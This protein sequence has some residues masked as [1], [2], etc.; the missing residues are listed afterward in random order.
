MMTTKTK[1][2]EVES[3][4]DRELDIQVPIGAFAEGLEPHDKEHAQRLVDQAKQGAQMFVTALIEL[5]QHRD[6]EPLGFANWQEL[7][8]KGIGIRQVNFSQTDRIAAAKPMAQ[9]GMSTR[10]AAAALDVGK[11]TV[12]RDRQL[13]QVGTVQGCG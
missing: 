3:D 6:W 5:W 8:E 2:N 13:A 12:E 9:A 4:Q 11:S 7:C 1:T 10:D